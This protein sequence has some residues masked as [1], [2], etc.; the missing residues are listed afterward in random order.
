MKALDQFLDAATAG[1]FKTLDNGDKV[2]FPNGASGGAYRLPDEATFGRV[3]A[4]SRRYW[5]LFMAYIVIGSPIWSSVFQSYEFVPGM[6]MFC[7]VLVL[8][9]IAYFMAMK[10]LVA[11]LPKADVAYSASEA[12]K[13]QAAATPRWLWIVGI[14]SS[15]LFVIAGAVLLWAPANI[16]DTVVG[17]ICIAMFGATLAYSIYGLVRHP[18][19]NGHAG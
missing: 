7:G 12:E 8:G 13:R 19:Q 15:A 10:R 2:F 1:Q 5:L 6:A 9:L 14:V 4:A 17:L 3:H 16:A 18:E 11:G